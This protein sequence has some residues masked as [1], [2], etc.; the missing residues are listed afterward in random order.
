[1]ASAS[2]TLGSGLVVAEGVLQA[3]EPTGSVLVFNGGASEIVLERGQCLGAGLA[4][5]DVEPLSREESDDDGAD[6]GVEY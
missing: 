2:A 5:E 6:D 3:D 4:L 1:M